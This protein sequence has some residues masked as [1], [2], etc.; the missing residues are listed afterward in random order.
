M[1]SEPPNMLQQYT[2][3]LALALPHLLNILSTS[4]CMGNGVQQ[5]AWEVW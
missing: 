2:K 5:L 3:A 4:L 1:C